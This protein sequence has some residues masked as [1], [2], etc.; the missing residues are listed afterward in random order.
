[1]TSRSCDSFLSSKKGSTEDH[2]STISR[3]RAYV[4]SSKKFP[5]EQQQ[6]MISLPQPQISVP[7][8]KKFPNEQH[9]RM[10]YDIALFS[11]TRGQFGVFEARNQLAKAA[12]SLSNG[13]AIVIRDI[14]CVNVM[15]SSST[16]EEM[17]NRTETTDEITNSSL[18][19]H[20]ARVSSIL[21]SALIA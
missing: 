7:S 1:M 11:G 8:S 21:T 13:F 2:Q 4:P 15:R 20:N 14:H 6:T 16:I 19:E 18:A 10:K 9:Q 12:L 17:S 5:I 3:R